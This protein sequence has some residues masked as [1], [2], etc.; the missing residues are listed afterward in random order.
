M[1]PVWMIE[2][3]ATTTDPLIDAELAPGAGEGEGLDEGARMPVEG[4]RFAVERRFSAAAVRDHESTIRHQAIPAR[5]QDMALYRRL[6]QICGQG[7]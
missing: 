4:Q 6:R 7:D 5:P 1:T 2:G 3:G